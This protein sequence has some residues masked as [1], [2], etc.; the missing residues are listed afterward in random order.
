[1]ATAQC[2]LATLITCILL[3]GVLWLTVSIAKWI[4][5]GREV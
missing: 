4:W 1:M 5:R 3:Y 2:A